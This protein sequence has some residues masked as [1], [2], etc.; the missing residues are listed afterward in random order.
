LGPEAQA[1]VAV[2]EVL[3]HTRRARDA[4][5]VLACDGI[6]DVMSNQE[7][8]DFMGVRI[9]YTAYGGP[10]GGANTSTAATACDALLE[11]CLNR[12]SIDNISVI[13]IILGAPVAVTTATTLVG[14]SAGTIAS[15]AGGNSNRATPRAG[16]V[17][18]NQINSSEGSN[19]ISNL[20]G[21]GALA[22][23]DAVLTP[24]PSG[25]MRVRPSGKTSN[26]KTNSRESD[27]DDETGIDLPFDVTGLTAGNPRGSIQTNV[28][29]YDTRD[30]SSTTR[31]TVS[32]EHRTSLYGLFPTVHSSDDLNNEK[33]P[34][35]PGT[36]SPLNMASISNDNSSSH[37][38]KQLHF[39]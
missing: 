9:G 6:W 31:A 18:A 22:G 1:V 4:F 16:S 8:V 25:R 29:S 28:N 21:S 5:I 10:A 30:S 37:V 33:I 26:Q 39:E 3:V 20:S 19:G 24:P 15:A 13:L 23:G 36:A 12:G 32:K 14:S 35:Q 11:E 34:E 38:R 2:P 27:S 7:V 17:E